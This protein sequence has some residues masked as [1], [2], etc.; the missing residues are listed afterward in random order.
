MDSRLKR[1]NPPK[2]KKG[3]GNFVATGEGQKE[4]NIVLSFKLFHGNSIRVNDFNNY[5]ENQNAAHKTV[6]DLVQIFNN[7]S[8]ETTKSIFSKDKRKQLH[9]NP[10]DDNESIKIIEEVLIK[11]YGFP[12]QTIAEFDREYF[13]IIANG[14]GGRLIFIMSGNLVMP[15]FIDPNHLIYSK[16][17]KNTKKKKNYSYPGFFN[18]T[19]EHIDYYSHLKERRGLKEAVI[20]YARKGEYKTV[21][22]F[23]KAWDE[24]S[25]N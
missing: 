12:K 18:Y 24:T 15:L 3:G 17:S 8:R 2:I 9:L 19:Q 1:I 14:D 13:E 6:S 21:E 16:V 20:G 7:I 4:S 22:D 25:A 11:G 5:Y 10:M 23:L